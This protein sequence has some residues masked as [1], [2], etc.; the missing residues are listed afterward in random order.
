MGRDGDSP[1]IYH[2]HAVL[3]RSMVKNLI[4]VVAFVPCVILLLPVFAFTAF[5]VVFASSVRA[6]ARLLGPSFTPWGN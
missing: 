3:G 5:A 4:A 2:L 1:A 6:I